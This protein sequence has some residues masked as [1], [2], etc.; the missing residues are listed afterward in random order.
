MIFTVVG[1][2]PGTPDPAASAAPC[3][4]SRWACRSLTCSSPRCRSHHSAPTTR[5]VR[6]PSAASGAIRLQRRRGH[7][8]VLPPR[9]AQRVQV[10]L[11]LEDRVLPLPARRR[12]DDVGVEGVR[13]T[14]V[15]AAGRVAV[16]VALDAAVPRVRRVAGDA[17]QLQRPAVDPRPV[18]VLVEQ[19]HRTVGHDRVEVLLARKAAREALH[20]P[21][22]AEDPRLVR[23]LVGVPRDHVEVG[24]AAEH[25]VEPDP[26]QV[27]TGERRVHVAV[28][29]PGEHQP[30]GGPHHAGAR[31]RERDDVGGVAERADAVAGHRH[32]GRPA[33]AGQSHAG[34]GHHEVGRDH[35]AHQPI[36]RAARSVMTSVAPPPMPRMRTSR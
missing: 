27:P 13:R 33:A 19:E 26:T 4:L 11:R 9:D 18:H 35:P 25:V 8:R 28:L 12:R 16:V 21:A 36:R 5:A 22:A 6:R 23:V 20:R 14:L 3:A 31:P 24:V 10:A 7:P 17:A 2:N 1:R 29:E 32:P 34:I 15:Q 30:A